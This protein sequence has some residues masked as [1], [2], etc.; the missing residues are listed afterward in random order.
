MRPVVLL[1]SRRR[2]FCPLR[3]RLSALAWDGILRVNDW[4]ADYCA[5]KSTEYTRLVGRMWLISAVARAFEPGAKVDH[6]LVMEGP[7]GKGKSSTFDILAF[8]GEFFLG[9][10]ATLADKAAKEQLRGKW[11]CELSEL[12]SV[13]RTDIDA[14]KYALHEPA[15]STRAAA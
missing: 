15:S 12:A 10:L 14:V 13:R 9:A 6:V 11:I 8:D 4:M 1:V 3:D 7:Q 5:A 2:S